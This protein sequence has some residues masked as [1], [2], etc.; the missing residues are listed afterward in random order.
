MVCLLQSHQS[1]LIHCFLGFCFTRGDRRN[2]R[3][4]WQFLSKP[5][6]KVHTRPYFLCNRFV[7]GLEWWSFLKSSWKDFHGGETLGLPFFAVPIFQIRCSYLGGSIVEFQYIHLWAARRL[8]RNKTN[9]G[10]TKR[11][12][13]KS[14]TQR[15]RAPNKH[16]TFDFLSVF[17]NSVFSKSG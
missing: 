2:F 8:T 7:L 15:E 10:I 6:Q 16:Y 11:S 1:M 14:W 3:S 9:S 4:L 5:F 12:T 17:R 13:R